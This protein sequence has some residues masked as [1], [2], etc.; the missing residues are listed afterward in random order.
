MIGNFFKLVASSKLGLSGLVVFFICVLVAI[1]APIISPYDPLERHYD[2][3]GRLLRLKPPSGDHLLG[4]TLLGRDVFSQL[5]WGARPG[6]VI[7]LSTALGVIMIGVNIGLIAGYYGGWIDNF[8]MRIT[9]IF[10]GVP[11]LPFIIVILSLT[12]KSIWTIIMAMVIIMWR[13]TARVIRSQ[14]LSLRERP[15]VDAARITGASSLKI[16]YFEI[17]PNILPIALVN[18]A[19]ALAWAII[20]EASIGFLGFGDP[21]V[22]SWGTIIYKAFASQMSYKAWWWVVPPGAAIMMLVTAVYFIGRAYE[23]MVNPRLKRL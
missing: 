14:V 6:L 12:G 20:T 15:F 8:L 16:V 13:S 5:L 3:S 10:M 22:I 4:T 9:D 19:F 17:A 21:D 11:F 1:F 7:G 23:E 18:I 2:A